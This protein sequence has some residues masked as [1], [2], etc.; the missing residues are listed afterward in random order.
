MIYNIK[1]IIYIYI[2]I[3]IYEYK[4]ID[5]HI[6]F[7]LLHVYCPRALVYLDVGNHKNVENIFNIINLNYYLYEGYQTYQNDPT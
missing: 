6:I 3:F 7:Y 4:I 5:S 1:Y 2:I